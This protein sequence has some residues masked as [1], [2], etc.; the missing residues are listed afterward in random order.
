MFSTVCRGIPGKSHGDLYD[1]ELLCVAEFLAFIEELDE[2]RAWLAVD[3]KSRTLR[4]RQTV[5]GRG[6]PRR[7]SIESI[8]CEP[9]VEPVSTPVNW[10]LG[11]TDTERLRAG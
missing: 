4:M 3:E 1:D 11:G 7:F 6:S 10:R 8:T 2:I 5:W 9:K